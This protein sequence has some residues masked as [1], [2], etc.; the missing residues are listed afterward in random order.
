M[1]DDRTVENGDTVTEEIVFD[2]TTY[3]T[4]LL[5]VNLNEEIGTELTEDTLVISGKTIKNVKVQ[6]MVDDGYDKQITT[7]GTGKFSF[8]LDTSKEGTYNITLVFA[9]KGYDTRRFTYSATRSLTETTCAASTRRKPSSPPT[10]PDGQAQGLYRPRH[11]LQPVRDLHRAVRRSMVVFMAMT[12]TKS[13]YKNMV[14]VTTKEEP[15]FS[16]DSLQK[17]YGT[18][19]GSYSVEEDGATKEY[20][21]FELLFWETAD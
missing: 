8:K 2:P 10:P 6:C 3:Q 17:M 1:A 12:K 14:V 7:N 19:T 9:K 4:T 11:G 15:N 16:V 5:P 20:P 13:G 18:C 21:A